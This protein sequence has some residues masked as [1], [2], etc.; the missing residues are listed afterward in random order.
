MKQEISKT[1]KVWRLTSAVLMSL[2][3][4]LFALLL[5]AFNVGIIQLYLVSHDFNILLGSIFV[6]LLLGLLTFFAVY[7]S[8]K[9]W[10]G[11]LSANGKTMLPTW[12][13]KFL[14]VFFIIGYAFAIYVAPSNLLLI[15]FLMLLAMKLIK[16]GQR[17]KDRDHTT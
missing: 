6:V 3:A 5:A 17:K 15:P 10:R 13:L 7:M 9:F 16:D 1:H 12:F 8:W 11:S 4:V 14:G 2:A